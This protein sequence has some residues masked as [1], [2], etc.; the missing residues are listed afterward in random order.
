MTALS[1]LAAFV[2]MWAPFHNLLA[3]V[4]EAPATPAKTGSVS[5]RFLVRGKVPPPFFLPA[6]VGAPPATLDDSWIVNGKDQSLENMTVR[7]LGKGLEPKVPGPSQTLVIRNDRL[8]PRTFCARGG[9]AIEVR[10]EDTVRRFLRFPPNSVPL[11]FALRSG[12]S[13]RVIVGSGWREP[14]LIAHGNNRWLRSIVL[15][16]DHGFAAVSDAEGRFKI[17][18]IP[19]GKWTLRLAHERNMNLTKVW[20]NGTETELKGSRLPIEVHAG[21]NSLGTIA[22][23]VEDLRIE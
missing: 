6:S 15:V 7:L 17:S 14:E 21:D 20:V 12:E 2:L 3:E 5:G 23:A 10:N 16:T 13:T 19:V 22:I 4:V 8:V 18:D 11:S 9:E 1:G